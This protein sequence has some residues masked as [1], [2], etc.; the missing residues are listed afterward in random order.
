MPTITFGSGCSVTID[1]E[2]F[3]Y[4]HPPAGQFQGSFPRPPAGRCGCRSTS[5][6]IR[7]HRRA[8]TTY[9]GTYSEGG[10]QKGSVSLIWVSSFIRRAVLEIDTLAGATTPQ[11]V[12]NAAGTG[13][14]WFD[15]L[16]QAGWQLTVEVD[17]S[18]VAVP[19]G[20][21]ANQCWSSANLHALM[22][23]VRKPTTNLDTE[24]RT[25][26]VV[27]PA[28][29]GCLARRDVRPDRRPP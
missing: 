21:N 23:S 27:V 17:Q 22:L 8:T 28:T 14:D 24:W 25:H 6:P 15:T 13:N 7:C 10:V 26:L 4:T 5:A 18:N 1:V 12:P 2:Q 9:F 29:M 16:A 3:D 19:A 11:P 20:V